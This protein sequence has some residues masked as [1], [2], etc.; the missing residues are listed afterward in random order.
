MQTFSSSRDPSVWRTILV[1]KFLQK[2][3]ENMAA[4]PRFSPVHDALQKGLANVAKWYDKTKDTSTYFICLGI[5]FTSIDL[6]LQC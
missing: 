1:L 5:V 6:L 3:W 2:S 4:L